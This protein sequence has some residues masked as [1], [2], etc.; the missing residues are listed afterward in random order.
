M[1]IKAGN[2]YPAG[3]LSN[4]A[5]HPFVFRGIAITSME[6]LLQ[7]LKFKNPDMQAHICTLVGRGAKRAGRDKAWWKTQTLWWQGTPIKR[8]SD[9]YQQLL[10][11]AYECM[12]DQNEKARKALLATN[13]ANLTHSIGKRKINETVLTEQEFCSRLTRNR[14]RLKM[15]K[16]F[17]E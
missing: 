3:A 12:F 6:G 2:P 9:E 7:G 17:E 1:D 14:A 13:E 16:F 5:A 10:D 11:E 8:D 15:Q 4:F